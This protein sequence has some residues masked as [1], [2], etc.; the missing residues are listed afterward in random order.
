MRGSRPESMVRK[1]LTMVWFELSTE[2]IA[3][4]RFCIKNGARVAGGRTVR[5]VSLPNSL[6]DT[7]SFALLFFA[8]SGL[9]V[10]A[11]TLIFSA[12]VTNCCGDK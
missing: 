3:S 4:L 11:L 10:N 8:V 7:R 6:S 1:T 12:G 9:I 5:K 2:P